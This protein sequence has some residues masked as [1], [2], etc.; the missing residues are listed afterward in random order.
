[1]PHSP[2]GLRGLDEF[3]IALLEYRVDSVVVHNYQLVT[4]AQARLIHYRGD[5]NMFEH[6]ITAV[7]SMISILTTVGLIVS[8]I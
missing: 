8:Y 4:R 6:S 7:V 1:V 2:T 5:E 3:P